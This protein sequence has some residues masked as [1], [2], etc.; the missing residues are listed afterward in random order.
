MR[1]DLVMRDRE[2]SVTDFPRLH[3]KLKPPFPPMEAKLVSAIPREHGWQYE[4]KWDGFRGLVFRDDNKV[5]IQ[6]KSGQ[7]LDRYFPEL[8]EAIRNIPDRGFV[9]DG[10]III[11]C[12]GKLDFDALLQRIHPAPS[13][14]QRL[15]R[16]TPAKLLVFDFL[17]DG[18][19]VFTDAPLRLRREV[20]ENWARTNLQGNSLIQLSPASTEFSVAQRWLTDFAA[21]GCD[22]V[23][24][25]LISEPYH[26]GDRRAMQ[27]VKRVR[28]AECVV[29]GFRYGAKDSE[30]GSLLLGL[31]DD[32]GKL[33]HV[34]FTSSFS[35][36]DR[37]GLKDII[38]KAMPCGDVDEV[39]GF[40]GASPGGPSRWN[41]YH[42]ES[43]KWVPLVPKLVV[44][45]SYDHFSGGRFRHGTKLL[46]W[47]PDKDPRQC[48]KEQIE[49]IASQMRKAA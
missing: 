42:P 6:S 40:S 34:G 3:L 11:E 17:E 24:A 9:L 21:L 12:E 26:S 27:K 31:Y 38:E 14:I 49:S 45:V 47:R 5:V 28:T 16:E 1:R 33:D 46:R 25:K 41:A 32:E 29:G 36:A 15:S 10:E 35:A 48:T 22:G 20:L 13:R 39:V 18:S 43:S 37:R 44:E 8:V 4:P 30:I 23:V 2:A 19:Q 7:P